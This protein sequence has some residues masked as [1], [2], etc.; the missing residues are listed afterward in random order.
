M[1][2]SGSNNATQITPVPGSNHLP[3]DFGIAPGTGI[4]R[5]ITMEEI[6]KPVVGYE[7]R[8]DVSNIGNVRSYLSFGLKEPD[9]SIP[10]RM[11]LKRKSSFGYLIVSLY[12]ERSTE[13]TKHVHRIVLNAFVGPCPEGY[14]C[15]HKNNIKTDNRVEN[16][17]WGT[18]SSNKKDYGT[19]LQGER[20]PNHKLTNDDV[21][22]IRE[23]GKS[24][25]MHKDIAKLF[26]VN[27]MTI[28]K[29]MRNVIW[30]HLLERD[31]K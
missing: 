1:L 3:P 14:E 6:W 22:K 12:G 28:G 16:L 26:P 23:L 15:C 19:Q 10:Q 21:L 2:N 27:R 13:G 4:F 17:C 24:G 20:H 29:I 25:V 30:K 5:S 9:K 11:L 7:G 18:S 8:Y 31:G